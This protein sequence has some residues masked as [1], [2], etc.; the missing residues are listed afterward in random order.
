MRSVLR[1]ASLTAAPLLAAALACAAASPPPQA[2]LRPLAHSA[3]LEIAG[4]STPAGLSLRILPV[5]P[6]AALTVTGVT[7]SAGGGRSVAA[8]PEADGSWLVPPGADA[9]GGRTTQIVVAHDGIR[10]VLDAEEPAA[11][12][13]TP[14]AGAWADHK[15]LAWWVLNIVIVLIAAFAISR[16]TS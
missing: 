8:T 2:P 9:P 15:Q 16:R 12:A 7:V 11:A 3:Q 1:P 10:E 13:P 14:P 6:G 4:V 5:H